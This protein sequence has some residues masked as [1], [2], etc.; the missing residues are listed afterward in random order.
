M[1]RQ[2]IT[3]IQKSI[4]KV[5]IS[6]LLIAT[7]VKGFEELGSPQRMKTVSST[8]YTFFYSLKK[9]TKVVFKLKP[10]A[11]LHVWDVLDTNFE[12]QNT[13]THSITLS[14]T[15]LAFLSDPGNP[16]IIIAA[17]GNNLDVVRLSTNNLE[18]TFTGPTNLLRTISFIEGGSFVWG[19]SF[20]KKVYKFDLGASGTTPLV[21]GVAN[22][23]KLWSLDMMDPASSNEMVWGLE[24]S[25]ILFMDRT[26][27]LD[28]ANKLREFNTPLTQVNKS[29]MSRIFQ[30][31]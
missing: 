2:T 25:T 18:K 27:N 29:K 12:S 19:G 21:T 10:E 31:N 15:A 3:N 7:F 26:G 23:K 16:D 17:A 6:T 22:A 1:K 11:M 8:K 28:P 9:T 24:Q 5:A 4:T 13:P 20:D 14:D 30:E